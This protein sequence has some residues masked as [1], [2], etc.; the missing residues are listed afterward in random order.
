MLLSCSTERGLR[1]VLTKFG[2]EDKYD[3]KVKISN[4]LQIIQHDTSEINIKTT[5]S[6]T[7]AFLRRLLMCDTNARSVKCVSSDL[8]MDKKNIINPLDLITGLFLCSDK[9]LQQN[10]VGK[11][12]CQFAVTL[13]LP[14]TETRELTM[15][16]W[17]MREIVQNFTPLQQAFRRRGSE[18][19][20]VFSEMPLVSFARLGKHFLSKSEMLNK[21]LSNTEQ[22]HDIFYHSALECG[23]VPQRIPEGLVKFSWYLPCGVLENGT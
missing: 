8:E 19:R 10:M 2:L 11:M 4:I 18:E 13:L 15:M 17:S 7:E 16:L 1:E 3:T 9:F 12:V 20:L 21:L 23:D 5:E 22:Y 6:P 14:N